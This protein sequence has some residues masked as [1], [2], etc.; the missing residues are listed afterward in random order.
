LRIDVSPI[1][2]EKNAWN[3]SRISSCLQH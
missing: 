2:D 1:L 3:I